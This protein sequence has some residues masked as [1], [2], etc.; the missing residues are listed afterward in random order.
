MSLTKRSWG[1]P[2]SNPAHLNWELS[3]SLK[4]KDE[5]SV[6]TWSSQFQR[7]KGTGST[8]FCGLTLMMIPDFVTYT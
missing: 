2:A 4:A 3:L 7:T 8:G 6:K 5:D 1:K